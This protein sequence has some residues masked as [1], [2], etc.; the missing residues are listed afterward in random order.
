MSIRKGRG[1]SYHQV[2]QQIDDGAPLFG[3][4]KA[5]EEPVLLFVDDTNWP[6]GNKFGEKVGV[7]AGIGTNGQEQ[8][9]LIQQ[10][11]LPATASC[12]LLS[13]GEGHVPFPP[14]TGNKDGSYYLCPGWMTETESDHIYPVPGFDPTTQKQVLHTIWRPRLGT[15]SIFWTPCHKR[16]LT[17]QRFNYRCY[18]VW[19]R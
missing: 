4:S 11:M 7:L 8:E 9:G 12:A 6:G 1:T 18:F 14:G 3:T 19:R 15:S 13:L 5:L 16:H 17:H 2:P 10:S